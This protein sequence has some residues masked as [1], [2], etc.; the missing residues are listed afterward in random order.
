MDPLV[1]SQFCL[2]AELLLTL[3]AAKRFVV[4]FDQFFHLG[5]YMGL[6]HREWQRYSICIDAKGSSF[7][8]DPIIVFSRLNSSLFHCINYGGHWLHA[9]KLF[10]MHL[11]ILLCED[12]FV[13][14]CAYIWV[15]ARV[16]DFMDFQVSIR[17]KLFATMRA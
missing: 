14:I 13:A 11:Q 8:L 7:K 9:V 16:F 2:S 17:S 12:I 5:I 15:I 10:Q 1:V 6:V 3:G 4:L